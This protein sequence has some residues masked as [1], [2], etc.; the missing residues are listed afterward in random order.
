MTYGP[1]RPS[2]T[3]QSRRPEIVINKFRTK[4]KGKTLDQIKKIYFKLLKKH[5]PDHGGNQDITQAL[6]Q[7]YD[8]YKI[9]SRKKNIGHVETEL[10]KA[11]IE[12]EESAISDHF[13]KEQI[14]FQE[15]ISAFKAEVNG[16]LK[17]LTERLQELRIVTCES[18]LQKEQQQFTTQMRT[19]SRQV[20]RKIEAFHSPV[21]LKKNKT[22]T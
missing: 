14:L 9:A 13:K 17:S 21:M 22:D 10:N 5:H 6:I 18:L 2:R 11:R 16:Y 1:R 20:E 4:V 3:Q 7:E 12:K 15:N 8:T 19:L